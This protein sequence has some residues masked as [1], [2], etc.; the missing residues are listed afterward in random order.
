MGGKAAVENRC[1]NYRGSEN[2]RVVCRAAEAVRFAHSE[3]LFFF[4]FF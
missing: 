2:G 3:R 4:F 1:G